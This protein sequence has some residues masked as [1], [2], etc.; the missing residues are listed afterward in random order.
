MARQLFDHPLAK[1]FSIDGMMKN[2]QAN[3]AAKEI[4]MVH[5]SE[6]PWL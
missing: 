4:T 3:E 2:M 5:S 6:M 1:Q